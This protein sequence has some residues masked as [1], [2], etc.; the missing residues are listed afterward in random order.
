MNMPETPPEPIVAPLTRRQK[1]IL[2]VMSAVLF[3]GGLAVI[4][5]LERLPLAARLA[6]GTVDMIGAAVLVVFLRQSTT[7]RPRE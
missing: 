1:N 6:L 5:F 7:K 4:L 2:I 3:F